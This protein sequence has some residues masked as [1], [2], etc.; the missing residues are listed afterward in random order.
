LHVSGEH[1]FVVPSLSLPAGQASVADAAGSDAVALFLQRAS[2]VSPSFTLTSKNVN[3]VVEI[4]RRL[5]GLPLA[6]ELAAARTKVLS[7]AALLARLSHRLELL[8]SGPHDQPARL[9]T[10]RAAI[11]WSHDLLTG[12]EQTL[13]RRLS[14][15]AGGFTLEAAEAVC[16]EW[17]V[18][19]RQTT[20]VSSPVDRRL[21]IVDSV[22]DV[23]ASLVDKSLLRQENGPD[24]EPRFAI[25]ETIREFGLERLQESD[26]GEEISQRHV[27]WCQDLAESAWQSWVRRDDV[28]RIVNH[29]D[30]EH[31]NLRTALA[32]LKQRGATAR[33]QSLAGALF[34]FWLIRGYVR[35]GR[36]WLIPTL[37]GGDRQSTPAR[38]RASI[39]AGTL[40]HYMGDE[41]QSVPC[42]LRGLADARS[43][44]DT[45]LA[46]YALINLGIVELDEGR[47]DRAKPLFDEAVATTRESGDRIGFAQALSHLG[48]VGWALGEAD[49][50]EAIV[51]EALSI[52]RSLADTWGIGDSLAMLGLM[53]CER[54]DGGQ[55]LTYVEESL[56]ERLAMGAMQY[57]PWSLENVALFAAATMRPH[58]AIRLFGIATTLRERFA[59][60]GHEPEKSTYLRALERAR[61]ALG[62]TAF[63]TAWTDGR[64]LSV[65]EGV[66][67]AR[68]ILAS[69]HPAEPVSRPSNPTH[70]FGLTER[71]IEVLGL[72]AAGLSDREVGDALF[73]SPRTAQKH[74]ATIF[75]KLG[76]N[77]RTA[78]ATAALRLGIVATETESSA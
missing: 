64:A 62:E 75:G 74:A 39:G 71:E 43:S 55:A 36:D 11:A 19:R 50:A 6:I 53:A 70:R 73:I 3:A 38:A 35:E 44:G 15:F 46:A 2:V 29:L 23:L 63:Q 25:L 76:V 48:L 65:D 33:I 17:T 4:C 31:E 30:R 34:W 51:H 26:E 13:F 8:T 60:P 9:Q 45:W 5:D 54:G 14:V 77:S 10:M 67:E 42:L 18:D 32:H 68:A 12:D 20:A 52:Q 28:D 49:T 59:S 24:A 66:A 22:L 16:A 40:A 1:E 72:I 7:P 61:A 47:Y 27:A 78:A 37:T 58:E 21:S 41:V 57:L 56:N 69:R